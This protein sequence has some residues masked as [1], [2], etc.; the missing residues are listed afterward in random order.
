MNAVMIVELKKHVQDK[1]LVFWI[2]LLP[3]LFTVV[4]IA[5]FTAGVDDTARQE[6]IQ[7]I[8]PAYIVMFVFFIMISMVQVF[9]KDRDKGMTARLASTPLKSY[10][11]LFGKWLPFMFIVFFQIIVLFLFGGVVYDISFGEPLILLIVS[12]F[13]TFTATA[14]GLAMALTVNTENMGIAITQIIALGGAMLSGLWM[15][16]EMLPDFMQTIAQFLPQYWANQSFQD[17]MAGT[18]QTSEL[19]QTLGVLFAIG[20]AAFMIAIIRYPYFLKRAVN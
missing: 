3:I 12:L 1:G 5:I 7:S 6:V 18:T 14:I 8:V 4:F 13:I 17:A 20:L 19:F 16:I 2:F 10:F 11:Y 15:P 9:I